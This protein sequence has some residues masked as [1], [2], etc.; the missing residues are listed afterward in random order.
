MGIS[1]C[2]ATDVEDYIR[3]TVSLGGDRDRREAIRAEIRE[4]NWRVFEDDE[5]VR[6][7]ERIFREL[8]A[9]SVHG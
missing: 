1:S 8:I 6:E 2:V 9:G 5:S 4:A 3:L 7:H